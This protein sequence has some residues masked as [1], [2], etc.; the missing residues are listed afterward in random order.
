MNSKIAGF[1]V[2]VTDPAS[3]GI[4]NIGLSN[5]LT[6]FGNASG[7]V[8]PF[9]P[10]LLSAKGSLYVT[11]PS[12]GA[13]TSNRKE[14]EASAKSLFLVAQPLS[15]VLGLPLSRLILEQA[16]FVQ[17]RDQRPRHVLADLRRALDLQDTVE[18]RVVELKERMGEAKGIKRPPMEPEQVK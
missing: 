7:A 8:A 5:N 13:Y 10:L 3:W 11:R 9:D 4:P 18:D 2:K 14:L 6:S 1:P 15:Q 16:R 12:L 17:H